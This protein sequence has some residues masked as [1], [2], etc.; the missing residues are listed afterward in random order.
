MNAVHE[1]IQIR[2]ATAADAPTL[3]TMLYY[4]AQ[5]SGEREA[6][7]QQAQQDSMLRNYVEDWGRSGDLGVVAEEA[8]TATNV[9]AATKVGAAWVR[10]GLGEA[11][12]AHGFQTSFATTKEAVEPPELA[13]AV[14]PAYRNQHIGERLLRAL[15]A[16]ARGQYPVISLNV[17]ENNPAVRLYHRVGFV[18]VGKIIN[19]VGSGSLVMRYDL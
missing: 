9:G 16:E 8:S 13:I 2:R 15:I 1:A 3:W 14:L 7:I 6:A 12:N 10:L 5:M 19:R 17:R 18:T 4:A 11:W